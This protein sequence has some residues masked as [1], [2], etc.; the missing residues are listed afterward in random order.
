MIYSIVR[1][2][3]LKI[4]YKNGIPISPDYKISSNGKSIIQGS[5]S[6]PTHNNQSGTLLLRICQKYYKIIIEL[7]K[8]K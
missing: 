3:N 8:Y 6:I 7:Y 2:L 1:D 4:D 5:F